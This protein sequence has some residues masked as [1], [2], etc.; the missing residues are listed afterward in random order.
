MSAA[1]SDFRPPATAELADKYVTAIRSGDLAASQRL[2][3][4]DVLR[5]APLEAADGRGELRGL[6]L[7]KENGVR[8]NA[9]YRI[10]AVKVDD[11]LVRGDQFAVRFAF[12]RTHLPT[13][14]R[15]TAVKISL[16]TVD[17]P[18]IVREEV[19]YHTPP[20]TAG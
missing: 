6:D 13:G 5:I 7:V 8:L 15:E 18:A 11:P 10:D 9:D 3:A 17:G 20:R 19:Y 12:D 2:L 14:K 1:D 4:P 16:Y